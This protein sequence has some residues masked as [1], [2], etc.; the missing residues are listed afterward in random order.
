L[1]GDIFNQSATHNHA[2]NLDRSRTVKIRCQ[3]GHYQKATSDPVNNS[4][5]PA[6]WPCS[7][8]PI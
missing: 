7:W 4:S 8:R 6:S 1:I 3:S 2:D 5:K